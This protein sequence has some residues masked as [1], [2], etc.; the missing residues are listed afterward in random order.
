MK[1]TESQIE[2]SLRGQI[3]S[4]IYAENYGIAAHKALADVLRDRFNGK[5]L[6]K[7]VEGYFLDKF[8]VNAPEL[9]EKAVVRYSEDFGQC[10][11]QLWGVCCWKSYDKRLE[12]FICNKGEASNAF[13]HD[14]FERADSCHASPAEERNK[15]R[16][17]F[18]QGDDIKRVAAIVA[19]MDSLRAELEQLTEHGKPGYCCSYYPEVNRQREFI[20][21]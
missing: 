3:W 1:Q 2:A 17:A 7:R 11:L 14:S 13:N 15:A 18:C 16:A 19:Q 8:F 20:R 10:K 6:T 21:Y 4:D 12:M 5:K 9:K